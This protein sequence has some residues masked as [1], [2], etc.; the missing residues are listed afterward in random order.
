MFDFS[1]YVIFAFSP[2]CRH[3]TADD[4]ARNGLSRRAELPKRKKGLACQEF[5][6]T[7]HC[8][9]FNKHKHCSLDHP[10]NLHNVLPVVRRCPQCTLVWPCNHCS[11]CESRSELED[12]ISLLKTKLA[13]LN[14]IAVDAPPLALT[15]HLVIPSD[16]FSP[17]C[18]LILSFCLSVSKFCAGRGIS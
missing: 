17:Q 18:C 13:L 5:A 8:S 14:Q 16:I 4:L 9:L 2:P 3:L 1:Q 11:F 15:S 12:A 10:V 7:G 6:S